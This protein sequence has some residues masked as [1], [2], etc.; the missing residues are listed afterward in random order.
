MKDLHRLI[1]T[2]A[3]YKQ[4]SEHPQLAAFQLID[5]TN[6]FYWRCNTR[7]LDAEQIRDAILAVTGQLDLTA[8]G[9]GVPS[10]VPRRSIYLR[11]MRNERDAL[12]DVFD[13]PLFLQVL[14]LATPRHRPYSHCYCSTVKS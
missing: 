14:H 7:R 10:D 4:S 6:R 13:L 11:M 9:P 1:V 3:T 5:P 2:S 12:L 8:G